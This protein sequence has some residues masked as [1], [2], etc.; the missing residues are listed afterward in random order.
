MSDLKVYETSVTPSDDGSVVQLYI[1][2]AP[3]D[4]EDG[5]IR[6]ALTVPIP[7]YHVPLFAQIQRVAIDRAISALK[8]ADKELADDLESNNRAGMPIAPLKM[9]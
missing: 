8:S 4:S 1:S 3:R 2:D 5:T 9:R 6:I 7:S